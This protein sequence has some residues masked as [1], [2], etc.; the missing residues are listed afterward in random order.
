MEQEADTTPG[1][2][3]VGQDEVVVGPNRRRALAWG[4]FFGILVV[5]GGVRAIS[6]HRVS[7]LVIDLLVLGTPGVFYLQRAFRGRALIVIDDH[8]FTD[9]LSE[10]TVKWDE[11]ESIRANTHQGALGL[12]HS[13]RLVLKPSPRSQR[14]KRR[15]VTTNASAEDEIEVSLDGLSSPWGDV[16][17]AI[18]AK[19]GRRVIKTSNRGFA[20]VRR[21]SR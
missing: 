9:C 3:T 11:I 16:V 20:D 7:A 2:Y 15:L 19:L 17:D 18:E 14:A 4:L 6:A 5:S 12:D 10:R 8:G 13:V 1:H 21:S